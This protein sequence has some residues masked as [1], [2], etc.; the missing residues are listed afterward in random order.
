M[1]R[2]VGAG[3]VELSG[4]EACLALCAPVFPTTVSPVY[5]VGLAVYKASHHH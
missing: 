5:L 4:R 2:L 1:D 3:A